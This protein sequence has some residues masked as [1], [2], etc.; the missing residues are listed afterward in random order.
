MS[1]PPAPEW[2]V[3]ALADVYDPCCRE[4][5]I[6]VVDM[7]LLRSVTVEDGHARVELLLTSGWCP[8]ASRVLDDVEDAV[9]A[10]PGIE[11]CAV[12]IVW[13]EVWSTDR[14]SESARRLLRFLP[15]PVAVPDRDAY[16][17]AHTRGGRS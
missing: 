9:R 1:R 14:L 2:A 7:G 5:G 11:S 13:D 3:R 4:K 8:F 16:I 6:S 15:E 10:Q 12:E 17:A